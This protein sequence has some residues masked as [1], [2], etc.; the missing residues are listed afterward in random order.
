[1]N[2][3]RWRTTLR[4]TRDSLVLRRLKKISTV[5]PTRATTTM[6]RPVTMAATVPASLVIKARTAPALFA[7]MAMGGMAPERTKIQRRTGEYIYRGTKE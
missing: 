7:T 1:M 3:G 5:A 6:A 4:K 2:A